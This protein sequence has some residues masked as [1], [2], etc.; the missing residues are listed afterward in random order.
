M[1]ATDYMIEDN[2]YFNSLQENDPYADYIE[3]TYY[4]KG[5][6]TSAVSI[7][8]T[9]LQDGHAS[10]YVPTIA[11]TSSREKPNVICVKSFVPNEKNCA[12]SAI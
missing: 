5:T 8:V 6:E 1:E 7:Y 9:A 4:W 2:Q 3:M 11:L 10:L 12:T